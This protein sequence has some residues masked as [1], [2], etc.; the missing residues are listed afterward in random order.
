MHPFNVMIFYVLQFLRSHFLELRS[1][2]KSLFLSL[3]LWGEL[4]DGHTAE[5]TWNFTSNQPPQDPV[6]NIVDEGDRRSNTR[7]GF[8]GFQESF[9]HQAQEQDEDA[10]LQP[11]EDASVERTEQRMPRRTGATT[12]VNQEKEPKRMKKDGSALERVIGRYLDLKTKQAQDEAALLAKEKEATQANDY[13]IKR[14]ISIL[15]TMDVTR[16]EKVKASEVFIIPDNRE[17]FISFS[18]DDPETA[19]LSLR[20]KMD[21]L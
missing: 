14:C 19:L 11:D 9:S 4:Y 6:I 8:E 15:K 12:S 20:G 2:A 21:K 18:E 10:R 17:I 16:D 7:V 5:G 13:S 1:F 3:K